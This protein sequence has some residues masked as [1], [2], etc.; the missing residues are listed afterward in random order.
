MSTNNFTCRICGSAKVSE[1]ISAREMM[2]GLRDAHSYR[3]CGGCGCVQ[4]ENYPAN[5]SDYYPA[6]YYSLSQRPVRISPRWPERV[7]RSVRRSVAMSFPKLAVELLHFG[8]PVPLFYHAVGGLGLAASSR[9]LD[10]GC[11]SGCLLE[12][13]LRE[14]FTSVQGYDPFASVTHVTC[15]ERRAAIANQWKDVTGVFDCIHCS[16]SFEHMQDPQLEIARML[17]LL[18][19]TGCLVMIIPVVGYGWRKYRA[20]W[21]QLDAPRHLY[22]H[23]QGSVQRLLQGTGFEITGWRGCSTEFL[24]WGSEQYRQDVSLAE[25]DLN[26][27]TPDMRQLFSAAQIAQWKAQAEALNQSG[28][29]DEAIVVIRRNVLA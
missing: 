22:I 4:I 29:S 16:R 2:I 23:S 12:F 24:F 14:G 9:L 3:E 18:S 7:V 27:A 25:H 21:V 28:D 13:L 11:G 15:G 1:A 17:S 19:P 10:V 6:N 5:L 20:S 8:M 26:R